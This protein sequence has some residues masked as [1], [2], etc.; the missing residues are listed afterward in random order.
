M[1]AKKETGTLPTNE[2]RFPVEK[3]WN[4]QRMA[5]LESEHTDTKITRDS[6]MKFDIKV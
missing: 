4:P 6:T 1:A 3:R 2:G 5:L